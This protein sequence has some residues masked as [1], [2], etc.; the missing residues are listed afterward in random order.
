MIAGRVDVAMPTWN[1][2]RWLRD[3]L[4]SIHGDRTFPRGR[5]LVVDRASTDGTREIARE[6][7]CEVLTDTVS[8]GSA[9][10]LAFERARTEWVAL[11]DSDVELY[12]GWFA[13]VAAFADLPDVGALQPTPVPP[14]MRRERV[15]AAYRQKLFPHGAPVRLPAGGRGYTYC[16]LV[17]RALLQDVPLADFEAYEDKAI[18]D[19]V[20]AKGAAW[21]VVPVFPTH[22]VTLREN[23]RKAR[24]NAAG[25]REQGLFRPGREALSTLGGIKDGLVDSVRFRDGRFL[26][27]AVL[28]GANAWAG[29]VAP[30]KFRARHAS[31][32]EGAP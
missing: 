30:K 8:L 20:Q 6:F 23:A 7:G 11:V 3:A 15:L 31:A 2:A 16:T 24:W 17:R 29:Y 10:Q 27:N 25:R 18:S 32:R 5:I 21:W 9:R 4:A 22:H 12:D 26:A 28:T 1:S 13:E 14:W 19:A